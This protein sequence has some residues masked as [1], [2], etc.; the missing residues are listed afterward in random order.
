[1]LI[2][3]RK[4]NERIM[5]G[6]DIEVSVVDIKGDQVKLGVKAPKN[7]KV[8][9]QEVFEAIQAENRAAAQTANRSLPD[10]NQYLGE[11]ENQGE[12]KGSSSSTT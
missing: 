4:T 6:D 10:I 7:V 11:G 8:Y 2:L 5:I 12:S 9:R 1:M 3:A